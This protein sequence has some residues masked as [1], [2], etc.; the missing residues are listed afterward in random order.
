M[1]EVLLKLLKLEIQNGRQEVIFSSC[2]K[3]T[4]AS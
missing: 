2:R 3:D 1:D 4:F